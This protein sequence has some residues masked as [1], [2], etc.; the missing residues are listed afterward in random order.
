M[1]KYI[2]A[3]LKR[4]RHIFNGKFDH[5]PANYTPINYGAKIQYAKPVNSL[6][7]LDDK[8]IQMI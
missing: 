4:I 8:Q 1:T 5:S 2:P 3:A 7:I 6:P